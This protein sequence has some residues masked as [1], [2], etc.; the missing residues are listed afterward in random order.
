MRVLKKLE[1]RT[2]RRINRAVAILLS[3]AALACAHFARPRSASRRPDPVGARRRGLFRRSQGRRDGSGKSDALFRAAEHGDCARRIGPREFRPSPFVD[4]HRSAAA[5]SADPE[6]LQPSALRRRTDRSGNHAQA[7]RPYAA[8]SD[9][10]QGP[11]PALAA[12]DVSAHQG[13]RRR[14]RR[15]RP[16]SA[17][18]RRRA[19]GAEVYFSDLKDGAI[20]APKTTIYFGLRNMG[21]APAGSDRENSGHHHLL[22]D[23]ELPP[24]DQPIP[25]DFNHLHFGGGQ[26][27]AEVTLKAGEHTLQLADGRQGS[28]SAHAAG[29]FASASRCASSIRRCA[30]R[31][32]RTRGSISSDCSD[33]SVLPQKATIRFGLANMGVAP[34]GIEKPNTGHH[35]LLIDTKLPP[36]DQP[37]PSDFNHLHFGAGPDRGDGE[38]AARHAHAAAAAR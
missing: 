12:G 27:E 1:G 20:I 4:R 5:Q 31:R 23:T 34:A 32:R 7:R 10:R 28:H 30:S 6:R 24:L 29:L 9:G 15:R 2:S 3:V 25:S 22:I 21:V 18:R 13:A 37:I 8:A 16:R 19:P 38:P 17:V 14:H 36:L 11:R 33:W 26:T 35:H